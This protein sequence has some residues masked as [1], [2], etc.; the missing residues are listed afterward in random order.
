MKVDQNGDGL[1]DAP[2]CQ[3][4]S[5][6]TWDNA[7]A[8]CGYTLSGRTIVSSASGYPLVDIN[9]TDSQLACTSIG[10]HLI[11][12]EEW[13]TIARNIEIVSSNWSSSIVGTGY[14]YSGHNDGTPN[15]ALAADTNDS[16]GYYLTGQIIGDNQRRT[17]TLTNGQVI[18]DLVGN[19]YDWTDRTTS[20]FYLDCNKLIGSDFG[21]CDEWE[22]GYEYSGSFENYSD[23]FDYV[24]FSKIGYKE[25]FLLN[26]DYNKDNGLGYVGFFMDSGA[27]YAFLRGGY[28]NNATYAGVLYLIAYASPSSASYDFG[29]RCVVVPE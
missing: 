17:L 2:A 13:M 4:S 26:S 24:D 9:Q 28:W 12:N 7:K 23:A 14:I 10:G 25:L 15:A 27:S 22:G 19:V 8:T 3:Y 6:G 11:T 18:W 5:Y 1:G 20:D 16:N 21:Y 29:F